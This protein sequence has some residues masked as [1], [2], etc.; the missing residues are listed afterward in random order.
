[1]FA[2]G[3]W[4]ARNLVPA[5]TPAPL[6]AASTLDGKNIALTD[7]KGRRVLI[8]FFAPWCG[9]CKASVGNLSLL[10]H[11]VPGAPVEILPVALDYDSSAD[12]QKFVLDSG[13]EG[14]VALG[15]D[16]I[17]E[18]WR[19]GSYPTSYIVGADGAVRSTSVGYTTTL[20]MVFRLLWA[21]W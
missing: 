7:L 18:S 15:D 9:V 10:R 5:G 21:A 1:M 12:V 2:V 8:Y 17:S 13:L 6:L 14:R 20:G 16:S 19:I 11:F 3:L 4:Q